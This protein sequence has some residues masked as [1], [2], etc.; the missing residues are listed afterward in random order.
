[1][2]VNH[3]T[4]TQFVYEESKTLTAHEM[5]FRQLI[6]FMYKFTRDLVPLNLIDLFIERS[7]GTEM[8]TRTS[9]HFYVFPPHLD[10]TR[11]SLFFQGL[12]LWSVLDYEIQ[13][14]DTISNPKMKFKSMPAH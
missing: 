14:A 1:M 10:S 8:T 6:I 9:D 2:G 4:S 11:C 12:G 13:S 7:N 3:R 5:Y